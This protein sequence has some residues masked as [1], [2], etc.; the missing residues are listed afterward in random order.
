MN[1]LVQIVNGASRR[2][3]LVEEPRLR[4]VRSFDSVY[5]LASAAI[6]ECA[7]L[8]SMLQKC[9]TD[10]TVDYDAVY[11]AQS[12]W[13]LLTPFDHPGDPARLLV[14]GTGLTHLGMPATAKQCTRPRN[15]N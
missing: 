12:D 11:D 8:S 15:R 3:A 13:R 10:E 7:S 14:S 4:L 2:V 1:R 5:A 9:L 6:A